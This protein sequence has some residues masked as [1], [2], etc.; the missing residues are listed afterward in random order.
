M[1]DLMYAMFE[2]LALNFCES[3]VIMYYVIS[4]IAV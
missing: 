2:Y 3:T 4:R 1:N